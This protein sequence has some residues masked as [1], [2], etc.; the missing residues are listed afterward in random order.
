M[1]IE[2]TKTVVLSDEQ[3]LLEAA[4]N[5]DHT[6][7]VEVAVDRVRKF[8]CS[9]INLEIYLLHLNND[10]TIVRKTIDNITENFVCYNPD[11]PIGS[12]EDLIDQ[13]FDMLFNEDYLS[14]NLTDA[15]GA[16]FNIQ[17]GSLNIST[18]EHVCL[19]TEY[20]TDEKVDNPY[21][22]I[23]EIGDCVYCYQGVLIRNSEIKFL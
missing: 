2:N 20:C 18:D 14:S 23:V 17:G 12:R 22:F 13:G 16:M 21:F 10:L 1:N 7:Y 3:S 8:N 4:E 19:L 6:S 9:D 15:N 5:G 11:I